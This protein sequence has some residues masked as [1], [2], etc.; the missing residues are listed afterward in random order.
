MEKGFAF[1]LAPG[2]YGSLTYYA[3]IRLDKIKKGGFDALDNI[4]IGIISGAFK[5]PNLAGSG[6]GRYGGRSRGG[7]RGVPQT[8]QQSNIDPQK[9]REMYLMSQPISF[10]I[11]VQL[12][13]Q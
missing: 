11:N 5:K 10:W 8:Q 12:Y 7:M 9:M 4:H 1:N 6:G 13:K 3:A 2:A